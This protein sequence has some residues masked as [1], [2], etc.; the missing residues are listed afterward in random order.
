MLAGVVSRKQGELVERQHP[1]K[2]SRRGER[3]PAQLAGLKLVE[4]RAVGV[5]GER[6]S[7]VGEGAG[8]LLDPARAKGEEQ[9][10]VIELQPAPHSHGSP[11]GINRRQDVLSEVRFVLLGHGVEA[12]GLPLAEAERLADGQGP[13][14]HLAAGGDQLEP[15]PATHQVVEGKQRLGARNASTD[16][17]DFEMTTAGWLGPSAHRGA[18]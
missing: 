7:V 10:V 17:Y 11:L 3:D 1:A 16:N 5:V 15:T 13:E 4:K 9:G 6:A 8:E 2:S 18:L 12:N 14:D